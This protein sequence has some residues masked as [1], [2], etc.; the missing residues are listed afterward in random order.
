MRN[1]CSAQ[2]QFRA[3]AAADVDGDGVGEFGAFQELSSGKPVRGR[4][5]LLDPSRLSRAFRDVEPSGILRRS[6]F[7]YRLY[8]PAPE[9]VATHE[10]GEQK[11][12][13]DLLPDA[14]LAEKFWC[15]YAWPIRRN[16]YAQRTFFINQEGKILATDDTRYE[17]DSGPA[18]GA[19]YLGSCMDV[20][21]GPIAED[22][23]GHDG[24]LWKRV[25]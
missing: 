22:A 6:G 14:D 23:Q 9:G 13:F 21:V 18:V 20:L 2:T 11:T 24:N 25:N 10:V 8:L 12:A 4:G 1:I 19:A 15:C 5:A 7:C 17:G 16:R 3:L